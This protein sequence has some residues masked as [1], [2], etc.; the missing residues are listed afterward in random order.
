MSN[1]ER[2][3]T[4]I[5]YLYRIFKQVGPENKL[6]KD[7]KQYMND[8]VMRVA[9]TIIREAIFLA[10]N[11]GKATIRVKNIEV[12]VR[13]VIHGEG[14][15]R[16][17]NYAREALEKFNRRSKSQGARS[18]RSARSP[19]GPRLIP[20]SASS[21]A[22]LQMPI[23]RIN[24]MIKERTELRVQQGVKVYLAGA[25]EELCLQIFTV[26]LQKTLDA[27]HK[28]VTASYIK[29]ALRSDLRCLF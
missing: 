15:I 27:K 6:S 19:R 13:L 1:S 11:D 14:G 4:L 29:E 20:V 7:A 9:D 25:L 16:A 23:P 17:V 3:Q 12:A 21:R 28:M 26:S 2:K 18:P 10:E 8:L 5:S 22:G 24:T